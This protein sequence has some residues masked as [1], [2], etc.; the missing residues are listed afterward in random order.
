[1]PFPSQA[2]SC[3]YRSELVRRR[4]YTCTCTSQVGNTYTACMWFGLA[5]LI[6]RAGRSGAGLAQGQRLL[7]FSFGSGTM[8]SLLSLT[9]AVAAGEGVVTRPHAATSG[10]SGSSSSSSAAA[11]SGSS[12]GPR[13]TLGRMQAVLDFE[14]RLAGRCMRSVEQYDTASAWVA[15]AYTA[16]PPYEPHGDVADVPVGAYYLRGVDEM[17]RRAY[18]RR[19]DT[20]IAAND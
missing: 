11:A 19:T 7:L 4:P 13:F 16:A 3:I 10:S 1:M 18:A 9:V 20:L 15:A 8:A 12:S 2:G 17:H 5:S 6:W 14:Q